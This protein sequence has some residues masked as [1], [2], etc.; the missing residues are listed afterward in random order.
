MRSGRQADRMRHPTAAVRPG[1][2]A[3]L[4]RAWRWWVVLAAVAVLVGLP[5]LVARL[6]ADAAAVAPTELAARITASAAHPYSGSVETRGAVLLP[7]ILGAEEAVD[8]LGGTSRLRVWVAGPT[9]WRVDVL[10]RTGERDTYRDARGIRVWDSERRLVTRTR[11]EA[12]LGLPGAADLLPPELARRLVGGAVPSEL[13]PLAAARVAGR[14][15]P[16]LRIIPSLDASTVDHIDIWADPNTGVALRVA[17]VAK[18]TQ[19]TVLSSQFLEVSQSPVSAEAVTYSPGPDIE[20]RRGQDDFVQS[21]LRFSTI[22]LP[23][24]LGGLPRRPESAGSVATYGDSF[25]VVAVLALPAGLLERALPSTIATS[26]RPWGGTARV[27]QTPLVNAMGVTVGSV[28][29]VI[30]GPVTV[31]ELDRLAAVLAGASG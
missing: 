1:G 16:G 22:L 29:Y 17:V 18:S 8:L 15:V 7:D 26:K 30:A 10:T 25:G 24:E 4:K 28:S 13:H 2:A 3:W 20:R 31:A 19:R 14:A 27:V 23:S 11:G 6:P 21:A 9:S 5:W 12:I